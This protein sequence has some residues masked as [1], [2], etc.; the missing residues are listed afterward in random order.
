MEIMYDKQKKT[1]IPKIH[2]DDLDYL[3]TQLDALVTIY[4]DNIYITSD[5]QVAAL[6]ELEQIAELLK[7][8][9][10]HALIKHADEIIT[11]EP[12]PEV[13]LPWDDSCL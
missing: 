9:M 13:Q 2:I 11:A 5:R 8:R 7:M 12:A 3:A 4:R 1:H 6:N 10:Y